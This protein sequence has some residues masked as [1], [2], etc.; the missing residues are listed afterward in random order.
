VRV[1]ILGNSDIARR[2]ILPALARCGVRSVDI[3]SQSAGA[4][5]AWPEGMGGT[6]FSD[7]A[8]AI[9]TSRADLVWVST[10]NSRHAELAELALNT[11]HHVIIDKPAATT[12]AAVEHL[13][14]LA[15]RRGCMLAEAHVFAF[16]PQIEAARRVFADAG[17]A[18]TNIVAGFSYPPLPPGNFRH[19]PELGGGALLDLGPYAMALGRLF[20]AASP[21]D[22]V[23][24]GINGDR[25]FNMLATYPG[26]RC[27]VGHFGM[28]TGY[29][30][31]LT[32]LGP[33]VTLSLARAFTTPPDFANRV[34]VTIAGK[35]SEVELPPADSFACFFSA[36][37]SAIDGGDREAF[38]DAILADAAALERLRSACGAA[39]QVGI[40][41]SSS[42]R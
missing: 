15:R 3:A 23:C 39:H 10:V 12:P 40:D 17:S 11:G 7:Y 14:A 9:P 32:V 26:D 37:L 36:V 20:F 18:P 31:Q 6:A 41:P 13:V 34:Q 29:V 8:E 16:H 27:V 42:P 25:G 4:A 2:R 35:P 1:L 24:R 38:V 33:N 28:T 21:S 19:R 5:A 30:N 22:V